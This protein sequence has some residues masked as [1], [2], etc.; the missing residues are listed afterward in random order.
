MF[1]YAIT[2]NENSEGFVSVIGAFNEYEKAIDFCRR[3]I[4]CEVEPSEIEII[5]LQLNDTYYA[6][7]LE[8]AVK[9]DEN[10]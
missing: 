6:E 8:D 4:E 3:L 5:Q 10:D 2:R 1:I 9:E 7:F